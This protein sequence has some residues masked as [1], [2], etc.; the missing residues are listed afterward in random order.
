[1]DYLALT[2]RCALGLVFLVAVIGKV[3]GRAAYEAFRRSVPELVPLP[4]GAAS[5]VLPALVVAAEC[6]VVVLLTVER[7]AAA[8]L[9]LAAAVLLA[10]T[11]G[12]GRAL[13]AGVRA[14][15]RCFGMTPSPLG[16]LHL[17]RNLALAA[18]AVAGAAAVLAGAP[19][20]PHPAGVA[21]AVAGG[22]LLAL[23]A[24]FADDLAALFA[25][26]PRR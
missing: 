13:R 21:L 23:P 18:L 2:A 9:A 25:P 17:V 15:C 3:R 19:G 14:S 6:A 10:F 20:Q 12:I 7:T 16:R 22:A 11:A 1:M 5:A 24:V 8:G 4:R 26:A